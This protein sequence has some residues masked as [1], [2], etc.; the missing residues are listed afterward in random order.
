MRL[1]SATCRFCIP[2]ILFAGSSAC[3]SNESD[4]GNTGS[5]GGTAGPGDWIEFADPGSEFATEDVYDSNR[6][7]V[8]FDAQN[9]TM[10]WPQG[11]TVSGWTAQG[12]D[13]SWDDNTV[14]FQ[15]LFG[16]EQGERRAYFTETLTGTICDLVLQ[17]QDELTIFSTTEPPPSE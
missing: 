4:S 13:L 5:S 10:V 15:V 14:A 2:A 7:V 16:T 3:S 11:L 17:G 9:M 12:N 6:E 1:F 8:H